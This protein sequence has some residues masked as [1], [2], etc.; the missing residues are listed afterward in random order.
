MKSLTEFARSLGRLEDQVCGDLY[1]SDETTREHMHK[2]AEY[3]FEELQRLLGML[4][5]V[6][7]EVEELERKVK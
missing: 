2:R 5:L 7:E 1:M 4:R 6:C 3:C